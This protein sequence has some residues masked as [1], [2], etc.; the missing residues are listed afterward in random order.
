[1]G[2]LEKALSEVEDV[3]DEKLRELDVLESEKKDI[4]KRYFE[5]D[6]STRVE[7]QKEIELSIE[8][9][10]KLAEETIAFKDEIKKLKKQGSD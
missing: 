2:E 1:M 7:I 6:D 5:S 8:K 4:I 9:Y 3:L 10:K